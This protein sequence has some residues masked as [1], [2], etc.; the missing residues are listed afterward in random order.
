M[1]SL[2]EKGHDVEV[3]Q[4]GDTASSP[5]SPSLYSE[6]I[7]VTIPVQCLVK[8]SRLELLEA[9]KVIYISLTFYPR[10]SKKNV[11]ELKLWFLSTRAVSSYKKISRG[12]IFV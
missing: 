4:T 3:E 1:Y 12:I 11:V 6:T 8:D 2:G 7:D 9:S 10:S 5:E